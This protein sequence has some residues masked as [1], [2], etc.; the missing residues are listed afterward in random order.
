MSVLGLL[1][2]AWVFALVPGPPQEPQQEQPPPAEPQWIRGAAE[3]RTELRKLGLSQSHIRKG[4]DWLASVQR[5]DGSWAI[6]DAPGAEPA[7]ADA[8]RGH[9]GVTSLAILSFLGGGNLAAGKP[10]AEVV[11]RALGWLLAQKSESGL[12]GEKETAVYEHAAATLALGEAL[13]LLAR[14]DLRPPLERA[15]ARLERARAD[16]Q[17]WG[18]EDG[19]GPSDTSHTVWVLFALASARDAGVEIDASCFDAAR[20]WLD[21]MTSPETGRVGFREPGSLSERIQGVNDDF[22]AAAGEPLSAAAVTARLL[23][24]SR[25][26]SD[27]FLVRHA[28]LVRSKPPLWDPEGKT[29]DF[30]HWL[31]GS[32]AMHQMDEG[33]AMEE[34]DWE[35]WQ[36]ALRRAVWKAQRRN[37][38]LAGSIEPVD[39]WCHG[40][41]RVYATAMVLLALETPARHKR[42]AD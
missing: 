29:I 6:F 9:V 39:A 25:R 31:F 5:E 27:P 13:L 37:G 1:F 35:R 32:M 24:G 15:V 16:G 33:S 12:L 2:A 4:L 21:K 41:G 17:A 30:T 19:K 7:A 36:S 11:G 38:P 20:D 23:L 40:G 22:P 18:Y 28:A 26:E 34:G 3:R 10:D 14:S 8:D 42:L